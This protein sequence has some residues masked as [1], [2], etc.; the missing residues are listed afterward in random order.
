VINEYLE[1]YNVMKVSLFVDAEITINQARNTF[2]KLLSQ[3]KGDSKATYKELSINCWTKNSE[4]RVSETIVIF[5]FTSWKPV[6]RTDFL[7]TC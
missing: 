3:H 4:T 5:R 7:W 1:T 2:Y 6:L